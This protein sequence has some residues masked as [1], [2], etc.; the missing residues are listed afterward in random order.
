MLLAMRPHRVGLPALVVTVGDPLTLW[1][2]GGTGRWSTGGGTGSSRLACLES[3]CHQGHLSLLLILWVEVLLL[4]S[5]SDSGQ[6]VIPGLKILQLLLFVVVV[7]L[8]FTLLL[9]IKGRLSLES[10]SFGLGFLSSS[11]GFP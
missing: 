9:M 10:H 6:I 3:S 2:A 4:F 7:E 8:L 5:S 1:L 11:G